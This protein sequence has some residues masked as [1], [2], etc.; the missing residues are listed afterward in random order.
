MQCK[1]SKI[2]IA[3]FKNKTLSYYKKQFKHLFVHSACERAVIFA[4][5]C[6]K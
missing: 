2:D 5:L 4:N 1:L 3:S 6:D